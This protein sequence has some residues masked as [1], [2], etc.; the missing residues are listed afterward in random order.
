MSYHKLLSKISQWESEDHFYTERYFWWHGFAGFRGEEWI[1]ENL[2]LDDFKMPTTHVD[3]R[4]GQ[5][6]HEISTF[7]FSH[8]LKIKLDKDFDEVHQLLELDV[9]KLEKKFQKLEL[10]G[11]IKNQLEQILNRIKVSALPDLYLN[12]LLE[13]FKTNIQ[14]LSL[15]TSPPYKEKGNWAFK[16]K[17]TGSPEAKDDLLAL[18]DKLIDL[19]WISNE[20]ENKIL[21][22]KFLQKG[23]LKD[24]IIWTGKKVYLK[25]LIDH[26]IKRDLFVTNNHWQAIEENFVIQTKDGL[27]PPIG[28]RTNK[29]S[30][31]KRVL[32]LVSE[33]ANIIENEST[34]SLTT[35]K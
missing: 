19:H 5:T 21:L 22:F 34:T 10:I 14:K 8:N 25:T 26:L 35:S 20:G 15:K 32:E 31:N 7:S 30:S 6:V 27:I 3:V 33:M 13:I 1:M 9:L 28:I 4:T 16:Y 17:H 2:E 29:P 12:I 11:I 23:T 18:A 24:K